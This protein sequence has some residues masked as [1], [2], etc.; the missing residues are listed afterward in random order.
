MIFKKR[1]SLA[2]SVNAIVVIVIA[3]VV[4]GLGLTLTRTIFT[5][6]QDKIPQA[7]DL[8][9]LE[10]QPSTGNPITLSGTVTIDAG[11]STAFNVGFYSI[12]GKATDAIFAF[13]NCMDED[14]QIYKFEGTVIP[15][16]G[17]N[18]KYVLPQI[19]TLPETVE[20]SKSAAFNILIKHF[21][22]GPDPKAPTKEVYGLPAN[23]LYV[24]NIGVVKSQVYTKFP[25]KFSEG[26]Y[27]KKQIKLSISS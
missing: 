18:K 16:A 13:E 12:N 19:N 6:A 1:A 20:Q 17:V 27:E 10:A 23:K 21:S 26:L 15:D 11:D 14:G 7:L 22:S 8:T 24:C 4:L 25:T 3:F 9:A 2:L 5:G